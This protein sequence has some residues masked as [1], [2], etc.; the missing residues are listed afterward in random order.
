MKNVKI[1]GHGTL[2]KLTDFEL[3]LAKELLNIDEEIN[4][5]RLVARIKDQIKASHHGISQLPSEFT[6]PNIELTLQNN[7]TKKHETTHHFFV[8]NITNYVSRI[9]KANIS[10]ITKR[11]NHQN[12]QFMSF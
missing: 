6:V 2:P 7:N 11:T 8:K 10:Y 5:E 12:F 3:N 1:I 9:T 4:Q